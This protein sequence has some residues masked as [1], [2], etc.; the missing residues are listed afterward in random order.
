MRGFNGVNFPRSCTTL[1]VEQIQQA[2][3]CTSG[4]WQGRARVLVEAGPGNGR[5]RQKTI[6]AGYQVPSG[7]V[8]K[9]S[10]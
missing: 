2:G 8:E 4:A 7:I 10:K 1:R 5:L 9:A 6:G 3:M